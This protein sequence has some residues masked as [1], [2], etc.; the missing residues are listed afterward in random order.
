VT[1]VL[2]ACDFVKGCDM[3]HLE[4]SCLLAAVVPAS[5]MLSLRATDDKE[6]R[7]IDEHCA[8]HVSDDGDLITLFN[9]V[10]TARGEGGKGMY[11]R[12]RKLGLR[13]NA[14]RNALSAQ[15]EIRHKL[16]KA[17][18]WARERKD[19][20]ASAET[21]RRLLTSALA[22][23]VSVCQGAR[24]DR[25]VAADSGL[26][27]R[28]VSYVARARAT[29]PPPVFLF[30]HVVQLDTGTRF[31]GYVRVTTA[32]L[33]EEAP[34][35][36]A[37]VGQALSTLPSEEVCLS[38]SPAVSRMLCSHWRTSANGRRWP[39]EFDYGS[40]TVRCTV[41]SADVALCK[42]ELEVSRSS[43][44]EVVKRETCEEAVQG[45][46]LLMMGA[47]GHTKHF[48]PPL[49]YVRTFVSGLPDELDASQLRQRLTA[50]GL[51]NAAA[52]EIQVEKGRAELVVPDHVEAKHA[53]D[54]LDGELLDGHMLHW[55]PVT[56]GRR[57]E[58][59]SS[60]LE[61]SWALGPSL[62]RGTI[63]FESVEDEGHCLAL[64]PRFCASLGGGG[65]AVK[66]F[67]PSNSKPPS[68]EER[69]TKKADPHLVV[70]GL[71]AAVARM[72]C[73]FRASL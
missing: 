58:R 2:T 25:C 8:E 57:N 71:S 43:I 38:M 23:N 72:A 27:G 1:G 39:I 37:E 36:W 33:Q 32:S 52:V 31:Q 47:G 55:M 18:V 60:F 53:K 22:V 29:P 40:G 11:E 46:G 62:G 26:V 66:V 50:L 10:R 70:V 6:R 61:L 41:A 35:A 3:G 65:G 16:F 42:G 44:I 67:R 69:A 20:P 68:V 73:A 21:L 9:L 63:F 64:A 19:E 56:N 13:G 51:P 30:A 5:S 4:D 28:L 15:Q 54:L 12:A 48:L 34:L 7:A 17:G 49:A 14:V 24:W 45:G 59:E